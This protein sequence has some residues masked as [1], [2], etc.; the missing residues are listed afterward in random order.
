MGIS[1]ADPES[2]AG[3]P[4]IQIPQLHDILINHHPSTEKPEA[5]Y[6]FAEYCEAESE[7]NT[8]DTATNTTNKRPWRPFRTQLD[9]EFAE[10]FLD[11]HMNK[12]Q[13]TTMIALIHHATV[14]TEQFTL[15]NGSDLDQIWEFARQIRA[16]GVS[17]SLVSIKNLR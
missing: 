17:N 11:A 1:D 8:H 7:T 3:G 10:L 16:E 12:T 2:N 14:S 5:K 4:A 15:A 6:S 13:I 9:F